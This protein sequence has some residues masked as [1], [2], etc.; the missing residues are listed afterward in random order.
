MHNRLKIGTGS[1]DDLGNPPPD[2][3]RSLEGRES[4]RNR[5]ARRVF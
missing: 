1:K 5:V 3:L 4:I 2:T